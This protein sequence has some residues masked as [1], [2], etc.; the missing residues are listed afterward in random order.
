MKDMGTDI[1]KY[2]KEVMGMWTVMNW[3]RITSSGMFCVSEIEYS[4][5]HYLN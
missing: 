3:L 2:L 5:G 1:K 4:A